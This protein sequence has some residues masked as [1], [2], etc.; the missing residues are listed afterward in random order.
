MLK[1]LLIEDEAPIR[2]EVKE[3]LSLN[4]SKQISVLWEATS[5]KEGIKA[6]L[7]HEPDL[8]FLDIDL[9]DGTSFDILSVLP[10]I[11]F[12]IIFV[13]GYNTHAIKAIKLGA[14]DYLLKPID[15]DE[16]TEAVEKAIA[17]HTTAKNK[18][19]EIAIASNYYKEKKHN[20]IVLRTLE[21]QHLV[22]FNDII[23][24][25]SEGNYTTFFLDTEEIM[26]SKPLKKFLPLF[27]E[28]LFIK[29][30]QSYL[31]NTS[32]IAKYLNE[33]FL[34]T[35]TGAQIP[36]ATRRKEQVLQQI[37]KN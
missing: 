20:K 33:G 37:F 10:S 12:D 13:T 21:A 30:H 3:L 31:I 22:D 26:V 9:G 5:V 11:N 17:N 28:S 29:C 36:V 4:F 32:R 25:K 16:F 27:D 6:I 7:T 2:E 35:H 8:V 18:E 34:V 23:Y 14:L 24:C 15:E 19:N 1:V